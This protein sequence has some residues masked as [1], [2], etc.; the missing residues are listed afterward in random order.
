M[1]STATHYPAPQ[2]AG[3]TISETPDSYLFSDSDNNLRGPRSVSLSRHDSGDPFDDSD[4]YI[5]RRRSSIFTEVGL[6]GNDAILDARL[7]RNSRPKLQVRFRSKV[8][9]HET[10]AI[11]WPQE[12]LQHTQ[13]M[14][15]YFPTL[16]RLLFV[17]LVI[18]LVLP[19]LGNSPFF[20]AGI[21][22]IGAKAGPIEVHNV[23]QRASISQPER[24]QSDPVNICKRWAGQSAVVN[25]TLYYYGGQ[26]T[27]SADQTSNEWSTSIV[28]SACDLH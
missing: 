22:P 23:R 17:A 13:A 8:D 5:P 6:Q 21:S 28:C 10:E 20:K 12:A 15:P 14:P 9:I 26:L 27:T 11:D 24:R 4:D 18:A 19:S 1:T 7:R 16:P 3:S 25:G 2:Q